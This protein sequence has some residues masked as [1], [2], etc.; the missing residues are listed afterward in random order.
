[1]QGIPGEVK[2]GAFIMAVKDL[3]QGDDL[4]FPL[5]IMFLLADIKGNDRN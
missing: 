1:M 4:S 5:H 3:R 2:Q